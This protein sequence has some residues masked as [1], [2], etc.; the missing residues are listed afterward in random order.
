MQRAGTLRQAA[1]RNTGAAVDAAL[2]L[3]GALLVALAAQIRIPLP[4]TPVPITGQTFAVLLVGATLGATR[5]A[6]S[7]VL[8]VLLGAA[9]LPFYAGGAAGWKVVQGPTG[10]YLI[11]FVAAAWLTGYLAERRWDRRLSSALGAMLSGSVLIY[12]IGLPWLS[13]SLGT[14]LTKTLELGLYP[15]VPGDILKLYLAGAALPG[16]WK[17]IGRGEP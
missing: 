14:G 3:A 15:F 4:F 16:A 10:G 8:Y 6:A 9:G 2:I 11:G 1:I 13:W 7:L 12:L 17:V 5:G